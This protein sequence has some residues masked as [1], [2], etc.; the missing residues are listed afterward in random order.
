MNSD[1][2]R[3]QSSRLE[4][5]LFNF[6]VKNSIS[7]YL[8]DVSTLKK[9]LKLYF[10]M[11]QVWWYNK[12]IYNC[13]ENC[14]TTYNCILWDHIRCSC[15]LSVILPDLCQLQRRLIIYINMNLIKALSVNPQIDRSCQQTRWHQ[16]NMQSLYYTCLT[17]RWLYT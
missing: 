7:Y 3:T 13:Y 14:W 10:S 12:F 16:T 15:M 11:V 8:F 2:Y 9:I 4:Q 6:W 1:I 17:T 5:R